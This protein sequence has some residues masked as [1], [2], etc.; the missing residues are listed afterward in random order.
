MKKKMCQRIIKETASTFCTMQCLR[1]SIDYFKAIG[2]MTN[3]FPDIAVQSCTKHWG[4]FSDSFTI[5]YV[6]YIMHKQYTSQM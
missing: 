3:S 2:S 5:S 6:S 1:E 4:P